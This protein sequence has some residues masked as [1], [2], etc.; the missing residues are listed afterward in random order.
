MRHTQKLSHMTLRAP[1]PLTSP[2]IS[3]CV[4]RDRSVLKVAL[5]SGSGMCR[6]LIRRLGLGPSTRFAGMERATGT[7]PQAAPGTPAK[8]ATAPSAM[9]IGKQP[10]SATTSKYSFND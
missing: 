4:A 3:L 8:M 1:R 6:H 7:W 9:T 10:N 5:A 2:W